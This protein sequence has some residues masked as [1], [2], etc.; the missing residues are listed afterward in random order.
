MRVCFVVIVIVNSVHNERVSSGTEILLWREQWRAIA[1]AATQTTRAAAFRGHVHRAK[2]FNLVRASATT[3]AFAIVNG[4]GASAIQVAAEKVTKRGRRQCVLAR[5]G[6]LHEWLVAA[7]RTAWSHPRVT[8]GIQPLRHPCNFCALDAGNISTKRDEVSVILRVDVCSEDLT[9]RDGPLVMRD[10]GANKVDR[11]V[12]AEAYAH[13]GV[14]RTVGLDKCRST[15]SIDVSTAVTQFVAGILLAMRVFVATMRPSTM[16]AMRVFVAIMGSRSRADALRVLGKPFCFQPR[17]Q[18]FDL[19]ILLHADVSAKVN[20]AVKRCRVPHF[21][22]RQLLHEHFAHLERAAVVRDHAAHEVDRGIA[23]KANSH[24]EVHSHI[25]RIPQF[26]GIGTFGA[27]ASHLRVVPWG[28]CWFLVR[29]AHPLCANAAGLTSG[30][31]YGNSG[32][33]GD[34]GKALELAAR[35]LAE[36]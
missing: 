25:H 21:H 11:V 14:H 27:S 35:L 22:A 3:P 36:I 20:E 24:S 34:D 18:S 10:H 6:R 15:G 30:A 4:V 9:H 7:A 31:R 8:S 5:E 26:Q 13:I 23:A 1:S 29:G 2:P 19:A 12:T 16:T 17:I 33:A 32:G 28:I